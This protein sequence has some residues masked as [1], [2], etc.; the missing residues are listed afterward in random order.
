MVYSLFLVLVLII[1]LVLFLIIKRRKR[2][3]PTGRVTYEAPIRFTD[4]NGRNM[5]IIRKDDGSF[6]IV[7]E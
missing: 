7:E 5:K 2:S 3:K 1:L 6:E 4:P